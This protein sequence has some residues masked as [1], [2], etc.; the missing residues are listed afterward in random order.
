MLKIT[1]TNYAIVND[2]KNNYY[3]LIDLPSGT[4]LKTYELSI[5]IKDVLIADKVRLF[6]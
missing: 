3:S 1:G 5:P 6:E 2:L 4:L